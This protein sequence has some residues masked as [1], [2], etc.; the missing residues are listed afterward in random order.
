M[1]DNNEILFTKESATVGLVSYLVLA[2]IVFLA[3][4]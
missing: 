1:N 4:I 3:F 2:A